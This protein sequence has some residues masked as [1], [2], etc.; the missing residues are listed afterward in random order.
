MKSGGAFLAL[1][2]PVQ[3]GSGEESLRKYNEPSIQN[4]ERVI[5]LMHNPYQEGIT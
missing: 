2:L 4:L 1:L 3:E 5:E